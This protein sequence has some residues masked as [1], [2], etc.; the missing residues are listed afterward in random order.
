MPKGT[1]AYIV[2]VEGGHVDNSLPGG[3]DG[4]EVDNSLPPIEL[5]PLPPGVDRPSHP[6]ALPP[7]G[8]RP[9]FPIYIPGTPEH[10]IALP[11]GTVWP[12]LDPSDGVAA[13]KVLLLA[14]VVGAGG[15]QRVAR[16]RWIVVD[17]SLTPTPPIAPGGGGGTPTHPIAPERQPK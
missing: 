7:F 4:G 1:L 9:S 6:I 11:P 16:A 8:G 15:G 12:P 5:P 3:G 14:V 13:G 2:P 10:P 17:T